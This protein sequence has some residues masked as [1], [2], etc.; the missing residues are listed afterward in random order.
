MNEFVKAKKLHEEIIEL[1]KEHIKKTK[2]YYF[3]MGISLGV[4]VGI[5]LGNVL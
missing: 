5:I 4:A 3:M 1:Y 2:F